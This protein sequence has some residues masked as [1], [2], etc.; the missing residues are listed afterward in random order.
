[1]KLS[2]HA[3]NLYLPTQ[4]LSVSQ[5]SEQSARQTHC[6]L[7]KLSPA[8]ALHLHLLHKCCMSCSG[9]LPVTVLL[10]LLLLLEP[11]CFTP[12]A[13]RK[14]SVLLHALGAHHDPADTPACAAESSQLPIAAAVVLMFCT[15]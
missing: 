7:Q 4:L 8:A 10:L 14:R 2:A 3:P 5:A 12:A 1:M 6:N 15:T 9:V 11:D 13:L